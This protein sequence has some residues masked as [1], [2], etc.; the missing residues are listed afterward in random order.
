MYYYEVTTILIVGT[1]FHFKYDCV[2]ATSEQEAMN[3]LSVHYA[4]CIIDGQTAEV[5]GIP[6]HS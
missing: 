5:C 4:S 6:L 3:A 1:G 2:L